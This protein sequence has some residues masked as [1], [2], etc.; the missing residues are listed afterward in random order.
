[1]RAEQQEAA[2]QANLAEDA[3][4]REVLGLEMPWLPNG[5]LFEQC[6]RHALT[7]CVQVDESLFTDDALAGADDD[8]L[9]AGAAA[10]SLSD[11]AG[12]AA[13]ADEDIDGELFAGEDDDEEEGDDGEDDD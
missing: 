8:E 10:M 9:A 13:A 12:A 6:K 4:S 11:G 1:L 5:V 2:A 7:C 3:V